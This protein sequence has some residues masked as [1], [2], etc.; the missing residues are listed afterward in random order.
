MTKLLIIEVTY[1]MLQNRVSD[2][3]P[4]A[5]LITHIGVFLEEFLFTLHTNLKSMSHINNAKWCHAL[6]IIY[7]STPLDAS[8]TK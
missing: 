3:N 6:G 2:T 5:T 1:H 8:Y 7:S 4:H